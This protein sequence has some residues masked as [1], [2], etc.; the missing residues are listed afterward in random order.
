[1]EHIVLSDLEFEGTKTRDGLQTLLNRVFAEVKTAF[2][3]ESHPTI[4]WLVVESI[5]FLKAVDTFLETRPHL[6]TPE[7]VASV[8]LLKGKFPNLT[9]LEVLEQAAAQFEAV[10]GTEPTAETDGTPSE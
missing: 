5:P 1:M 9:P 6:K 7:F 2:W 10:A 8:F 4:I 3:K